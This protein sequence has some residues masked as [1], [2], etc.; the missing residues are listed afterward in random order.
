MATLGDGA[1]VVGD[2]DEIVGGAALDGG[3]E[4]VVVG[5]DAV[6]GGGRV[7][8]GGSVEVVGGGVVV[9]GGGS[10][11]GSGVGSGAGGSII[12]TVPRDTEG[13]TY[14]N[15]LTDIGPSKTLA[16]ITSPTILY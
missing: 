10:G 16:V 6:L 14:C 15:T 4:V 5:S 7:V 9:V 13:G 8:V 3:G 12:V 2:I 1:I 11:V